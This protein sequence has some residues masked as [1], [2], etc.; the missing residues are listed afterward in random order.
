MVTVGSGSRTPEG[1][2]AGHRDTPVAVALLALNG[3][4]LHNRATA[5]VGVGA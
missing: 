4:A 3:A 5:S 1:D 2:T